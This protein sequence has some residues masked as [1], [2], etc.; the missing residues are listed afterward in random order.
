M[1]AIK[2][3]RDMILALR[4]IWPQPE[5]VLIPQVRDAV[6]YASS[7]TADALVMGVW[8]SRGIYLHGI[9]V[10]VSRADWLREKREPKKAENIG[11]YC[12]YWWLAVANDKIVQDGELPD[13]W[14]LIVGDETGAVR[15]AKAA[16]KLD[17]APMSR[18]FLAEILRK[19]AASAAVFTDIDAEID[20]RVAAAVEKQKAVI[21]KAAESSVACKIGQVEKLRKSVEAFEAASGI[22]IDRYSDHF[23][24][25]IGEAVAALRYAS[26]DLQGKRRLKDTERTLE[27]T[28]KQLREQMAALEAIWPDQASEASA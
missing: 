25:E 14:G 9:E 3:E 7:R 2:S 20:K 16:V 23:S 8:Q 13:A 26:K 10:K 19:A 15:R 17:P 1:S 22:K 21:E 11:R 28:L 24:K 27:I 5:Y 6:G 18:M 4:E 12:D